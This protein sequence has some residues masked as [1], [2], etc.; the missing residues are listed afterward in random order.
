[1]KTSFAIGVKIINTPLLIINSPQWALFAKVEKFPETTKLSCIFFAKKV[2]DK[3]VENFFLYFFH[4]KSLKVLL[5]HGKY[6]LL[7]PT[8]VIATVGGFY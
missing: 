3:T 6:V 2:N 8:S 7:H 4:K 5:F 1:M